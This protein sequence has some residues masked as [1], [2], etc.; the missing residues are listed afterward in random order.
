[1][2]KNL[3]QC[4]N[5]TPPKHGEK[6]EARHSL[7]VPPLLPR[8]TDISRGE[9][10]SL[11]LTKNT[12]RSPGTGHTNVTCGLT[13]CTEEGAALLSGYSRQNHITS[14]SSR[15]HIS[16]PQIQGPLTKRLPSTLKACDGHEGQRQSEELT[17]TV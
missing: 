7:K 13:G 8:H 5:M 16:Q 6:T 10:G 14:I 9:T 17:Q 15:K 2:I 11:H 1:M 4:E 12:G 3:W